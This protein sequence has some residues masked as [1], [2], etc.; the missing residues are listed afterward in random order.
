M[1]NLF[2][3]LLAI[4]EPA[5][6]AIVQNHRRTAQIL[7]VDHTTQIAAIAHR[8]EGKGDNRQVSHADDSF[9]RSQSLS[10][11]PLTDQI[12]RHQPETRGWQR[13]RRNIDRTHADVFTGFEL[14]LL[15]GDGL[16]RNV[17]V[18][19]AERGG[20]N[21]VTG[22]PFLFNLDAA[23]QYCLRVVVRFLPFDVGDLRT[24]SLD[25]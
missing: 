21:R 3:S 14:D 17:D 23:F 22:C 1:R 10:L 25:Q 16:P 19:V 11:E 6:I 12:I 13:L 8:N 24:R 15:E 20:R 2:E 5:R 9:A 18:T 7:A 4:A